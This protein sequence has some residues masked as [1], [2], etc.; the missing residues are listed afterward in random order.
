MVC[1]QDRP[2]SIDIQ[3]ARKARTHVNKQDSSSY[4]EVDHLISDGRVLRLTAYP[5]IDSVEM[6]ELS[7]SVY[8]G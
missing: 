5:G 4:Y 1:L 6:S 2:Y 8:D 3:G 7:S